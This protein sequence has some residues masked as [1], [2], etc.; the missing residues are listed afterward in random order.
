MPS[1]D[2]ALLRPVQRLQRCL[3][4]ASQVLA[5]TLG[6]RHGFGS[7]AHRA[8]IAIASSVTMRPFLSRA[9]VKKDH[10]VTY[11][12][13]DGWLCWSVA[14]PRYFHKRQVHLNMTGLVQQ[15]V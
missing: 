2:A 1:V 4:S 6:C 15:T 12:Q 11:R 5:T 3:V 7:P 13:I 9:F 10:I 8:G 14:K